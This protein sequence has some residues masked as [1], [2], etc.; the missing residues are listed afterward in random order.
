M[1]ELIYD[2]LVPD[3]ATYLKENKPPP[4]G[5]R[6]Y[7]QLS[8]NVGVRALVSRCYEVIGM[9]KDCH[10]MHELRDKVARHYG[11][12]IVQ[13]TLALPKPSNSE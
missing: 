12:E 4:R 6:W 3:I 7:Q 9:A 1:I 8:E 13:L 11:R 2:T 5:V 10:D